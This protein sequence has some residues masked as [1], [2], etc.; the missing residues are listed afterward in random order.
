MDPLDE[1]PAESRREVASAVAAALGV[2]MG[3]AEAITRASE[4]LWDALEAVGGLVGWRR[5]LPPVPEDVRCPQAHRM[6]LG[7]HRR[8]ERNAQTARRPPPSMGAVGHIFNVLSQLTQ[9]LARV[10]RE[11][12]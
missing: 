4:P 11:V 7:N 3:D 12:A 1:L 2:T 6:N 9:L 10:E 5:V 8:L